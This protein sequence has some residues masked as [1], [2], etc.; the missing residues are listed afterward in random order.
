MV[1]FFATWCKPCMEAVPKWKKLHE[2]YYSKG[3]RFIV[4]ANDDQGK[5]A[6]VNWNPDLVICDQASQIMNKYQVKSLPQAFLYSWQGDLLTQRAHVGRIESAIKRYFSEVQ[7]KIR[8]DE[9]EVVGDKFAV[10]SNPEWLR[11]FITS[12]IRKRSK[13]DVVS[14]SAS[15]IASANSYQLTIGRETTKVGEL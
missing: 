10:S 3:L 12:E 15:K 11:D 4:I 5:C 9:I 6:N 8:L 14:T 7:L 13:F 2:K 1:E